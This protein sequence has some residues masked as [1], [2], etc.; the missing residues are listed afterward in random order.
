MNTNRTVR[1]VV[2]EKGYLTAEEADRLLNVRNLTGG[3]IQE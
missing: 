1:E 3:G 2:I